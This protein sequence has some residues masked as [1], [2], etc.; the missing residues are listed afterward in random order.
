MRGYVVMI[1]DQRDESP[2]PVDGVEV[3][4]VAVDG[5]RALPLRGGWLDPVAVSWPS[6]HSGICFKAA[7]VMPSLKTPRSASHEN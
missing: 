4:G 3:E 6:I 5:V 7:S 2:A 1:R